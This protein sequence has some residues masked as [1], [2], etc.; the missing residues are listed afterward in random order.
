MRIDK[1]QLKSFTMENITNR[2][3]VLSMLKYEDYIIHS[4][5]GKSIYMDDSYE[6]FETMEAMF[7]IHRLTLTN[8]GFLTNDE[9]VMNY[10][11]IFSYYY[12]NPDDYDEEVIN[13]VAYIRENK[14]IYYKGKDYNI[15]DNFEEVELCDLSGKP[16]K[17]K[18]KLK[19]L[20][21]NH[22]FV[23]AFSNS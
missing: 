11:K 9:D 18:E 20:N 3:L 16:F 10:R 15:G 21:A 7:S 1:N 4:D 5:I 23:G 6:H 17:L 8:F 12:K 22:I 19:E 2:D 14:C 13:A